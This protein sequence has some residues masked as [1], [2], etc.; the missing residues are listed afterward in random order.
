MVGL[1]YKK[2]IYKGDI[3]MLVD[4]LSNT[5]LKIVLTSVQNGMT[6][7]QAIEAL[8]PE[9]KRDIV[10]MLHSFFCRED[11]TNEG[12]CKFYNEVLWTEPSHIKWLNI[13]EFALTASNNDFEML[14]KIMPNIIEVIKVKNE[15]ETKEGEKGLALLN[16]LL[17]L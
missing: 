10:I 11:H 14:S 4:E 2:T 5:D 3:K 16:H 12:N 8:I 13:L 7:D 15:V 1:K 17:T 9:K 6:V